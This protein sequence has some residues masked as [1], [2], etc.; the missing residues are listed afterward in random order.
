VWGKF[1]AALVIFVVLLCIHLG[2]T[3]LFQHAQTDAEARQY[4]GPFAFVNYWRPGLVFALP[5]IVFLAGTSFAIGTWTRRPILVFAFPLVF[6]LACAFFLWQW[7]PPQLD[8]R[9]NF[10]LQMIDPFGWRWLNE[11]YVKGDRGVE[12]Y[13]STPI[14]VTF[15]FAVQRLAVAGFGIGAGRLRARS[16]REALARRVAPAEARGREPRSGGSARAGACD[17]RG[18]ARSA[19]CHPRRRRF[20]ARPLSLLAH[21][22][23]RAPV[24]AGPLP[25]RPVDRP[26]GGR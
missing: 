21:R 12:F 14:V 4:I 18:S 15:A 23:A 13:N 5:S 17:R 20:P 11:T 3:M 24:P 7:S 10:A 9:L 26:G 1:T 16:L 8:P 2:L 6:F 19:R 25:L 22:A